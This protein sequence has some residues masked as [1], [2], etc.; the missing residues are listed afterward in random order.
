MCNPAQ[1]EK[2]VSSPRVVETMHYFMQRT[3]WS[4]KLR[5]MQRMVPVSFAESGERICAKELLSQESP[6]VLAFRL[7]FFITTTSSVNCPSSR[8]DEQ[9][10]TLTRTC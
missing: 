10:S 3:A 6:T 5:P 1:P 7:T 8:A 4:L 9:L 2:N